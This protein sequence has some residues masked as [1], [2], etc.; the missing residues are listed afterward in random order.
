MKQKNPHKGHRKRLKKELLFKDFSEN[1][2]THKLLEALLFF[3]V[4]QKDTNVIAH[5]LLEEF[6]S[7]RGVLE[8]EP[9]DLFQIKNMTE[10]VTALI[11]LVLPIARRYGTEKFEGKGYKFRSLDEIGEYLVE[12]HSGYPNEVFIVTTF[13]ADGS[14]ITSDIVKKGDSVSVTL[15]MK[16][17]INSVLKHNAPIVV[18]SHN[19]INQP[20]LPSKEDIVMTQKLKYMLDQ[21]GCKLIDHI[22]VSGNDFISLAQS[23]DYKSLFIINE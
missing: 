9:E 11:K 20:A 18:F 23:N 21:I 16:D 14:K 10:N 4:P 22:I 13:R 5:E 12:K 3:G 6:G 17:I 15:P 19:H 8:A 7:L 2:E 1:T